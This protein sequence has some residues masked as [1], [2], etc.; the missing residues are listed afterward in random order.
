MGWSE[1]SDTI[2]KYT[3][4][5]NKSVKD[6][7]SRLYGIEQE[8]IEPLFPDEERDRIKKMFR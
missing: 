5:T 7:F 1:T 3:H 2:T 6:F 4:L 8:P